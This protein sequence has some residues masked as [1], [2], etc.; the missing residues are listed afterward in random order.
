MKR[1]KFI[2]VMLLVLFCGMSSVSVH[3]EKNAALPSDLGYY[4]ISDA[5]GQRFALNGMNF[6][7][8]NQD[9]TVE[10]NTVGLVSCQWILETP[11]TAGCTTSSGTTTSFSFCVGDKAP[12]AVQYKLIL[13]YGNGPKEV[14]VIFRVR[15]LVNP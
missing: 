10:L 9:V 11:E 8:I 2:Q 1:A 4:M 13:D 6:I 15:K 5:P 14:T 3:A 7:Q 12:M